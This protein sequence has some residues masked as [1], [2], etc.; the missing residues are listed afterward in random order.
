MRR[1][2]LGIAMI[3]GLITSSCAKRAPEPPNLAPGTPHVTWVLMYGD[4]DNADSEFACQSDPRTACVLPASRPDAQSFSDIHFYFHGA[5]AETRYEGTIDI[6][7][8]Q[9]SEP[10]TSRTDIAVQKSG[11][12][13]NQSVM[14]IVTSTPGEYAVTL[15]LTGTV[16]DA[17]KPMP[18]RTTIPVTVK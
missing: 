4:R 15:S 8:L 16:R 9:G 2:S 5:G 7:Y 12:I 18:I 3:V 1:H 13:T 17:G 11:S 6:G 14:G 10:H